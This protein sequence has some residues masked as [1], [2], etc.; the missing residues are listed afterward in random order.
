MFQDFLFLIHTHKTLYI[1]I[2]NFH[3]LPLYLFIYLPITLHAIPCQIHITKM[4]LFTFN[5]STTPT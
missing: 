4:I 3:L 2:H 1:L 5:L